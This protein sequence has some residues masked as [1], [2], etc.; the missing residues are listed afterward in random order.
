[1]ISYKPTLA[2][3]L[4]PCIVDADTPLLAKPIAAFD[5]PTLCELEIQSRPVDDRRTTKTNLV[6]GLAISI[7][8]NTDLD[9][10][11][12]REH[13]SDRHTGRRKQRERGHSDEH[14]KDVKELV[15]HPHDCSN[16]LIFKDLPAN[17]FMP[18]SGRKTLI[19]G[20]LAQGAL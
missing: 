17:V 8:T 2:P 13:A 10:A 16:A 11:V 7:N 4:L 19:L 3:G 20:V 1:M 15:A 18:E 12:R 6:A 9:P 5:R 14:S